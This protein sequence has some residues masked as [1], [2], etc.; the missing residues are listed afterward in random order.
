MKTGNLN[1]HVARVHP[2]RSVSSARTPAVKK[3]RSVFHSHRKRN[4]GIVGAIVLLS[5][6]ITAIV[7]TGSSNMSG[8]TSNPGPAAAGT[9][10][11]FGYL[12][13]S[14]T[15]CSWSDSMIMSISDSTYIQGACCNGMV[16]TDYQRQ[17]TQ[18]QQ[19]YSSLSSI[20]APDPYNIP[21]PVA[22]ADL[23]GLNLAL[24]PAQQS[25]FDLAGTLSKES[26]CCCHCWA[27][28]F[29]QGMGKILI[30]QYG[31]SAQQIATLLTLED[32]CGS[33]PGPMN[34]G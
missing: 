3:T 33:A 34:M 4:I 23:N 12:S 14:S 30:S 25:A 1:G 22:K 13:Q 32:C 28:D 5:I 16:Y 21:A 19:N 9:Q 15:H 17:V 8:M 20:V 2:S 6:I 24:S 29:H 10:A 27:W 26:W 31:F 7:L 18:L 11:E